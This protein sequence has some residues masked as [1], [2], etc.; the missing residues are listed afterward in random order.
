MPKLFIPT[1]IAIQGMI[2]H[3]ELE[4]WEHEHGPQG[5]DEINIVKKGANYGW[6]VATYGIDYDNTIISN[7]NKKRHS[8]SMLLGTLHRSKWNGI[9]NKYYLPKLEGN[10]LVGSL[11]F[12]YVEMLTFTGDKITW[13]TKIATDVGRLRNIMESDGYIYT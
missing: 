5:G 7:N 2:K 10:L 12:Q 1:E 6:P 4:I 11:K 3:P 9:C 8:R 13:E